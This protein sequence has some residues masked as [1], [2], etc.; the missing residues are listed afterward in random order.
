MPVSQSSVDFDW[1]HF[2]MNT[3]EAVFLFWK[4]NHDSPVSLE[5][6][7]DIMSQ[8][9]EDELKYIYSFGSTL[10]E[11]YESTKNNYNF[12]GGSIK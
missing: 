4:L 2:K 6:F 1:L 9:P 10:E 3:S 7:V 8:Y 11:V 5:M 12:W